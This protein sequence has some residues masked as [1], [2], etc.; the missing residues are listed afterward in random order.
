MEEEPEPEPVEEAKGADEIKPEVKEEQV[1]NVVSIGV[2]V[3]A[4]PS[5]LIKS[6]FVGVAH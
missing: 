4:R 1:R 5:F 3:S 2:C 6:L